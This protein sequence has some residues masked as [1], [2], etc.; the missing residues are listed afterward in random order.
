VYFPTLM[1]MS[2]LEDL[3][4]R[5]RRAGPHPFQPPRAWGRRIRLRGSR[6]RAVLH[7]CPAVGAGP[8]GTGP[9]GARS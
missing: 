5:A 7:A 1:L 3:H 9:A 8:A 6:A 4:R 2:L